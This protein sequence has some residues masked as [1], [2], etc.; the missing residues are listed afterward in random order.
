MAV[1]CALNVGAMTMWS[2]ILPL[3]LRD[4][5]ASDFQVS[6]SVA[7]WTAVAALFQYRGGI[8]SDRFGRRPTLLY[9]TYL[10][11]AAISAAALM[12]SWQ[13]FVLVYILWYVANAIQGPT[14]STII[15][16]A[17]PPERHGHAFG[18]V[19]FTIGVG[20]V[21]GPLLGAYLL[22]L[23]RARGLLLITG[24]ICLC[25]A[26]ARQVLLRE[27]RPATAGSEHFQFTH[28]FS[29]RLAVV[30]LISVAYY[31]V[32]ST[33]MWG[34]FLALHAS[35]AMGLSKSQ[36]NLF[37]AAGSAVSA[38]SSLLA[39]RAV[40]R[41]G[42]YRVFSWATLGLGGSVLLWALQR[43]PAAIV[44]GMLAMSAA[45]QFS[46]VA[47]DAFRV[48][49]LPET[50]RGRA[51][52]A[53]GTASSLAAALAVPLAGYLRQRMELAPFLLAG[54]TAAV[55]FV[56]MRVLVTRHAAPTASA[57][58]GATVVPLPCRRTGSPPGDPHQ[59]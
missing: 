3:I 30:L 29:G 56:A 52:G 1:T 26:V 13:P 57:N 58:A 22:P 36:I 8:W 43:H 33:T 51:L 28:V 18:L 15:G 45:F 34:P 48:V 24:V 44:A 54:A 37:Y 2:P 14:F 11:G 19:E 59:A 10:A 55:M 25:T 27:T 16:E 47:S 31:L 21:A 49:T 5:G 9:P 17:V 39:G 6:L 32:L 23:V 35:D 41:W 42:V 12:P 4:L 50:I 40:A 7:T 53:I 46:M 20:V 38:L